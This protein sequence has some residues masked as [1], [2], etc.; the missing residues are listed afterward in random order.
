MPDSTCPIHQ[1][2]AARTTLEELT[3][4]DSPRPARALPLDMDCY[5]AIRKTA[6]S[7]RWGRG[8]RMERNAKRPQ[9][10]RRWTSP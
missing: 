6:H 9:E 1:G 8:G 4:E 2:I 5:L 10:G 7:P 3:H